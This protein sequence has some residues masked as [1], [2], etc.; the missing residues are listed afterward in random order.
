LSEPSLLVVK[1]NWAC[2]TEGNIP[3]RAGKFESGVSFSFHGSA[4][5]SGIQTTICPNRPSQNEY[6]KRSSHPP[7]SDFR[8]RKLRRDESAGPV[9]PLRLRPGPAF[10]VAALREKAAIEFPHSCGALPRPPA[11]FRISARPVRSVSPAHSD[12]DLF[13]KA[14]AL[15]SAALI[16]FQSVSARCRAAFQI[17]RTGASRWPACWRRIR[18]EK[19]QMVE[20]HFEFAPA[21]LPRDGM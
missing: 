6:R 9:R 18:V 11:T 13:H 20:R 21:I 3:H 17:A 8:L 2:T 4:P 16:F 10:D 12:A 7:S 14:Q 15:S 5:A 19:R 1:V